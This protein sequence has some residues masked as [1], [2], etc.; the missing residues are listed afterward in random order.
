[1]A[2]NQP[3][4]SSAEI[5]VP[6]V[7][8]SG[9]P[10]VGQILTATSGT[11]A[12]WQGAGAGAVSSVF[13]RTGAIVPTIGDYTAAQVTNAADKAS[14]SAQAFT[15]VVSSSAFLANGGTGA[16]SQ[17]RIVGANATGAPASG[18]WQQGDLAVAYNGHVFVCTVAGTP[19]TWVDAGSVGNLVTSVFGRAGAVVLTAADVEGLFT[20]A[21]QVFQGTGIGTGAL[22][23]PAG[24]EIAYDQITSTVNVTGTSA[25]S[26]TAIISGTAHTYEN[27][28]YLF[29]FFTVYLQ[30]P[31][32]TGGYITVTLTEDGSDIGR[33]AFSQN[34]V[35]GGQGEVS[36]VG[37]IRFTPSAGSH[38]FGITSYVSSTTGTPEV[39]AGAGGADVNPPAFLRITKC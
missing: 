35:S 12:D 9:T 32:T 20:A 19:G 5:G 34:D 22:V 17:M 21:N 23:I 33:I 39:R 36:I 15:A 16:A 6:A 28:P 27:V 18:T 2:V 14:A 1:M 29:T 8:V 37:Q 26:P 24:F 31:S 13:G 38:T 10:T 7:A 11:A 30:P 3:I 4:H 25:G